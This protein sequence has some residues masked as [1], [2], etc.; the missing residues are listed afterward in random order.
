MDSSTKKYLEENNYVM[1]LE[2][3]IINNNHVR[4]SSNSILKLIYLKIRNLWGFVRFAIEVSTNWINYS[5]IY[6]L[7]NSCNNKRALLVGNGPSQ[8]FLS[9]DAM[10]KFKATGGI[11]I[12]VNYW[13]DN[14][15]LNKCIPDYLVIS[16]PF[17]LTNQN[18]DLE[19][20][21]QE[22]LCYLHKFKG[23]KL[24]APLNRIKE[25]SKIIGADRL[26]G[27][28]DSE[29]RMWTATT[30]PVLPRGYLSMTLYKALGVAKWMGFS[31]IF[32]IGMDNTYPRNLY[33]D[34]MNHVLNL[35]IHAGSEDYIADISAKYHSIGE[36]LD[37]LANLFYDAKKFSDHS[38]INLDPF[39]LTD[40][41]TKIKCYDLVDAEL[42]H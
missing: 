40:A 22:L 34:N 5:N 16:D 6:K 20:K 10:L 42:N 33:C 8:G 17:T 19:N 25:L 27:F 23:I 39:S 18:S 29:T 24:I 15:Q 41:F 13:T 9:L 38:V 11:V 35:E 36:V 28:C 4:V 32:V 7:K 30:S 3:K 12:V 37:D 14:K 1:N 31:K 2:K 21:N 26:I